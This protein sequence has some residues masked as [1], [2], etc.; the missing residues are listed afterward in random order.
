[1]PLQQHEIDEAV[2]TSPYLHT[3][4]NPEE[5]AAEHGEMLRVTPEEIALAAAAFEAKRDVEHDWH[6]NTLPL[7]EA[8]H[9][10]GLNASAQELA[11]EVLLLRAERTAKTRLEQSQQRSRR[12][13]GAVGTMSLVLIL[14]VA[15]GIVGALWP[16]PS[17]S[18]RALHNA[19]HTMT[20]LPIQKLASIPDNTPVHI[21]SDTLAKLATDDVAEQDISVDTRAANSEGA[22]SATMFNNEWTIIKSGGVLMVRGWATAEFALNISNDATGA[23]F[24]SRPG[25]LAANNLVPIQVPVYRFDGQRVARYLPDGTAAQSAANSVLMAGNVSDG[26]T[27]ILLLVQRNIVPSD[28][29]FIAYAT[30]QK[31]WSHVDAKVKS[32]V[33]HLT[34][35]ATTARLKQLA[36]NVASRT[37][38]R[39]HIPYTVSNEITIAETEQ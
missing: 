34:G 12:I 19:Q 15:G 26:A 22:Q 4:R 6:E 25:W 16:N 14:A 10:L 9:H 11:P 13:A 23:L 21:D 37:L 31:G 5:P 28:E 27:A 39:L 38:Q 20:A 24:S 30:T 8:I 35:N 36:G 17:Q 7:D 2:V 29:N 32:N 1:M 18:R 33:L 3:G